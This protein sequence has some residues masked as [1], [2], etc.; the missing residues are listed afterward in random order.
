M[1]AV[2]IRKQKLRTHAHRYDT[3]KIKENCAAKPAESGSTSQYMK[4]CFMNIDPK[5]SYRVS[6]FRILSEM[7]EVSTLSQW[8]TQEFCSGGGSTNSVGDRGQRE[9]RSGGGSPIVGVL[10]AAVI[11]YK[12]FHFI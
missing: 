12:K 4:K 1:S 6:A 2:E 7:L 9:R 11:W 8:R 3:Y 10:E 5:R